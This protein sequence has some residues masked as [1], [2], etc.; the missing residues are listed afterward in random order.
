MN[1]FYK[2]LNLLKN[3]NGMNIVG[4]GGKIIVF[5][6]P[7]AA[8]SILIHVR[9]PEIAAL[10]ASF[11]VIH[12]V[13]YILL[14]L[15]FLLWISG[16]IQLLLYFPKGKLITTGAYGVCR[17]PI[18]SSFI[19]FILPGITILTLTWVYLLISLSLFIGVSLFIVKEETNLLEIFGNEYA[20]YKTKVGRILP[21]TGKQ[22]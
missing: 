19:L 3:A 16:V 8:L 22:T 2:I 1:I 17:N 9:L 15:G 13:G 6:L 11:N 4:Q 10:P 7:L 18:Y 20:E 5:S 14:F 21:F 12:P